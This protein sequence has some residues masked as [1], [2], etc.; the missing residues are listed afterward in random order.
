MRVVLS[1]LLRLSSFTLPRALAALALPSGALGL[2]VASCSTSGASS[3]PPVPDAGGGDRAIGAPC[4][5]TLPHPCEVLTD[6]CSASYCDP[7][8]R[9]CTRAPF[10]GGP[11]CTNGSPPTCTSATCDAGAAED[12]A[13]GASDAE[14]EAGDAGG[15]GEAGEGEGGVA[16]DG[17]AP[18]AEGP[19]AG[20]AGGE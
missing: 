6:V 1:S 10:D 2:A 9:V 14:E 4:D 15:P 17:A 5:P 16:S 7:V 8:A 3:P 20:D 11:T 13:D 18:D 19:E 12:A